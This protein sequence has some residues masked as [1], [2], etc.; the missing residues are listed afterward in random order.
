MNIKQKI[1][2][3]I[4]LIFSFILGLTESFNLYIPLYKDSLEGRYPEIVTHSWERENDSDIETIYFTKDGEFGYYC[5]CGNPVDNYDLCNSYKYDQETNTIKLKCL[6]GVKVT[7]IKVDEVTKNK[8]VLDFNGEKK[9]FITEYKHLIDNPLPFAGIKFRTPGTKE[10][11]EL[12]FT[13]DGNFE[14]YNKTKKEYT[15]GSNI[16]FNWTY[17]KEKSEIYLDCQDDTRIIKINKYVNV[18]GNDV[19]PVE[20]ELYFEHE[21]K[22]LYFTKMKDND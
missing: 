10:E 14:A 11:I 7:K 15:L 8:I 17:S 9:E 4:I 6:P 3:I 19:Y 21:D 12:E 22:T 18:T 16:C 5:A 2:L 1:A 13:K 20:L